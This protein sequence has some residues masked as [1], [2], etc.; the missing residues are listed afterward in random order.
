MPE[1][2]KKML[3]VPTGFEGVRLD[4][5][6]AQHLDFLSRNKIS[7]LIEKQ[8]VTVDGKARKVSFRL[9]SRQII[10]VLIAK[11]KNELPPFD[12]A[13]N[14]IY[15]D[16]DILVI[17]KPQGLVVHP[18]QKEY[19]ETLVN[20]LIGLKKELAKKDTLRAGI[21]HRLDKET[22]GVMVIA[23]NDHS[24]DSLV[25]QFKNRVVKKEYR[26]IFWGKMKED[27]MSVDA[28]LRRDSRNR[29][30]MK[31]G[32][33]KSKNAQTKIEVLRRL[34]DSTFLKVSPRTGRMHQIRVHLKFLEYPIVGDKKYGLKDV[35]NELFLHARFLS[36]YHPV[37]NELLT[38]ESPLPERFENFIE[39][40]TQMEN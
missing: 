33:S 32:I 39:E 9:H 29:L 21:V 22:S 20:A 14:I 2:V 12:F 16:A 23:K 10:N 13:V 31:V 26:A 18:P 8:A 4:K 11:E 17:D 34:D 3:V 30:K 24:Y 1:T 6:L 19:T 25:S 28:P 15:E 27:V 38:F 35:Y 37:S 40:H 5:F 36:F 7:K